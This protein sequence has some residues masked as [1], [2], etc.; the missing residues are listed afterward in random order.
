MQ[1]TAEISGTLYGSTTVQ[2]TGGKLSYVIQ[3]IGDNASQRNNGCGDFGDLVV[4]RLDGDLLPPV[5]PWDSDQLNLLS[6]DGLLEQTVDTSLSGGMCSWCGYSIY[7]RPDA[8][9]YTPS[10]SDLVAICVSP[11]LTI[12][13]EVGNHFYVVT[14]DDCNGTIRQLSEAGV[15]RFELEVES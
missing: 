5:V 3:V 4:F 9:F 6:F 11:S 13:A 2:E 7:E 15:F 12:S 8:P 14:A 1:I 10:M